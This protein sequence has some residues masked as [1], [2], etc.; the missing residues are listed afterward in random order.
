M[1][2]LLLLATILAVMPRTALATA[3]GD[4]RDNRNIA[5]F[6]SNDIH[7]ETELCG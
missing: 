4:D 5:I 3:A 2:Y 7:G 1:K 6:F